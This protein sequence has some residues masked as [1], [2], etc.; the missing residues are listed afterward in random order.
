MHSLDS[1]SHTGQEPSTVSVVS[2]AD[3]TRGFVGTVIRAAKGGLL[4][5]GRYKLIGTEPVTGALNTSG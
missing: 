3:P 5:V 1:T 4:L 2:V